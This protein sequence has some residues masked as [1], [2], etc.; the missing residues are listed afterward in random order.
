MDIRTIG[1]DVGGHD[2]GTI[3]F[4]KNVRIIIVSSAGVS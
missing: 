3:F 4:L 1:I 2:F